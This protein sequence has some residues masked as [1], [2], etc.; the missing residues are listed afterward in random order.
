MPTSVARMLEEARARVEEL[1]RERFAAELAAGDALLVD[2]RDETEL[3]RDGTIPGAHHVSRGLLEF[4]ADP[5]CEWRKEFFDPERRTIVFCAHG[6]RSLL[7]GATLLDLG[8]RNVAH[9]AGGYDE[10]KAA[11]GATVEV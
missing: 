10:W 3:R 4:F 7:A 5:A 9:L 6:F 1:D 8:F 2:L 11:G